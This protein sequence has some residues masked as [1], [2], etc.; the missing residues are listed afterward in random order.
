MRQARER[1]RLQKNMPQ[2]EDVYTKAQE[3]VEML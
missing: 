1:Q 3:I 2:S